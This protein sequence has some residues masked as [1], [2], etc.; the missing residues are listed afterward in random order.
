MR[1]ALLLLMALT[2][3][4]LALDAQEP[5]FSPDPQSAY[6]TSLTGRWIN[7]F[8]FAQPGQ[9]PRQYWQIIELLSDG[10]NAAQLLFSQSD[11]TASH[12]IHQHYFQLASGFFYRSTSQQ[13]HAVCYPS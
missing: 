1:Y 4:P 9:T 11:R 7:E 13:K 5:G 6:P 3:H 12:P 2:L 8:Y 10:S